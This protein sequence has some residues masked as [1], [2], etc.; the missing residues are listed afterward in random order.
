[1]SQRWHRHSIGYFE[2]IG[3][4]PRADCVLGGQ[5]ALLSP[6]LQ[7]RGAPE[8]HRVQAG[9]VLWRGVLACPQEGAQGRLQAVERGA[10]GW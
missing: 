3:S 7:R 5:D 8:E 2:N 10:G 6:W 9:A 4:L 1:M